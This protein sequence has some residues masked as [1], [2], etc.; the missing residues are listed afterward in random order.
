MKNKVTFNTHQPAMPF[1]IMYRTV[2]CILSGYITVCSQRIWE[3]LP[4][5]PGQLTAVH[6]ARDI[7]PGKKCCQKIS[8]S[9]DK[10]SRNSVYLPKFNSIHK[11]SCNAILNNNWSREVREEFY[12]SELIF[13][14]CYTYLLKVQPSVS[15]R[16]NLALKIVYKQNQNHVKLN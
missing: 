12:N 10:W 15:F 13:I 16:F 1:K 8:Q 5:Q 7:E 6:T 2:Q 4:P 14:I 3:G 11:E 9:K